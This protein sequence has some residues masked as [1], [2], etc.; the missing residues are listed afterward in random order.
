MA[1]IPDDDF[2]PYLQRDEHESPHEWAQEN[3]MKDPVSSCHDAVSPLSVN[4]FRNFDYQP[5]DPSEQHVSSPASRVQVEPDENVA[6]ASSTEPTKAS[7][8]GKP[9]PRA[10][11]WWF[12]IL[13]AILSIV[14]IVAIIIILVEFDGKRL[15]SWNW[16][17]SPNAVLSILSTAAKAVMILPVSE[18]ISQLKW[19]YLEGRSSRYVGH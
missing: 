12:E 6:P 18:S 8:P 11:G 1:A 3:L 2:D 16:V 15:S 7:T 13:S 4:S 10:G 19:I 9:Q 14:C 5:S 17:I